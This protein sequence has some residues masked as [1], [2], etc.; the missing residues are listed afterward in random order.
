MSQ[1]KEKLPASELRKIATAFAESASELA[2]RERESPDR[3][4]TDAVLDALDKLSAA[5][6]AL[7]ETPDRD[8]GT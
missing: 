3:I 6:I 8:A 1:S 2:G 5:V 4:T 7:A